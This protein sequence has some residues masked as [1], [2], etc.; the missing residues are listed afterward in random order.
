MHIVLLKC[1]HVQIAFLKSTSCDNQVLV[2][3]IP[4]P[5]VAVHLNLKLYKVGLS[6]H[7]VYINN[8]LNFQ[9]SMTILNAR[10]KKVLKLIVCTSYIYKA[11]LWLTPTIPLY[12]SLSLSSLSL[13][14]S[15]SHS[16]THH[17]Y[18]NIFIGRV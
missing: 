1:L 4:I 11:T 9:E 7:N 5:A 12:S 15:L 8:I 13:S 2:G 18:K 16:H 14:L 10:T 3:Y 6:S 17:T